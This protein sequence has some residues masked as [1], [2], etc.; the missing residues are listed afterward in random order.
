MVYTQS[1][2]VLSDVTSYNSAH[3]GW[4]GRSFDCEGWS[5]KSDSDRVDKATCCPVSNFEF[6]RE[7][8]LRSSS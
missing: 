3:A 4:R 7:T 2:T 5:L 8:V 1:E 6:E